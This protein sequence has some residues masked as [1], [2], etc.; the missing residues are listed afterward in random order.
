[1]SAK[2]YQRDIGRED[3]SLVYQTDEQRGLSGSL[4]PALTAGPSE[5]NVL[6]TPTELGIRTDFELW[7]DDPD[8][9]PLRQRLMQISSKRRARAPVEEADSGPPTV[10]TA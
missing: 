2:A 3:D 4:P 6:R 7:V 9:P 8:D 5:V 1:M 10:G